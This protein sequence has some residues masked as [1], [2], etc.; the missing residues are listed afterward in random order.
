M[1]LI[2]GKTAGFCYGVKRAVEGVEKELEKEK[3]LYCLGELVHNNQV[4]DNLEKKGLNF[5]E[6]INEAKGKTIIRA[7]GVPV[8]VYEDAEKKQIKL[9]EYTCP[10]VLKIHEIAKQYEK[11]GY[12]ICLCGS[13]AH[14]E[15]IGTISYCGKNYSVINVENDIEDALGK[16]NKLEFKK[17]LL[18]SQTTYSLEKFAKIEKI[19]RQKLS[20]KINL[21]V[22]NTIC[23]AT[24]FRQKETTEIA[25]NVEYMIIIGGKN[26]S[27]TKKLFEIAKQNCK[28]AICIETVDDL[29]LEEVYNYSKIG[30]MA[31]ASTPKESINEV[32]ENIENKNKKTSK[33]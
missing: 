6:N 3:K 30:I 8:N 22:K 15:N 26:S 20:K 24:E 11:E 9:I 17:V 5:I 27:N 4:I 1:E 19:L 25:K 33:V 10:N 31:G 16:I 28:K 18:I 21:I 2:V 14:P 29:N 23:K 12:Y 7:H 13:K 32:I